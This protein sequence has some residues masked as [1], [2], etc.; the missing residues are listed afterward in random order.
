MKSIDAH[1]NKKQ[2]LFVDIALAIFAS[3]GLLIPILF[4]INWGSIQPTPAG[5]TIWIAA[6]PPAFWWNLA[7]IFCFLVCVA[8][9]GIGRRQTL[10]AK[11]SADFLGEIRRGPYLILVA[12]IVGGF[13][14]A[15]VLAVSVLT[16]ALVPQISTATQSAS[17]PNLTTQSAL[18]AYA[19]QY[20]TAFAALL[21]GVAA[22]LVIGIFYRRLAPYQNLWELLDE[23]RADL[24]K[25]DH[26]SGK[27]K[28]IWWSYPGFCLGAY[29]SFNEDGSPDEWAYR[30]YSAFVLALQDAAKDT[31]VKFDAIVY[32]Q[33]CLESFYASYSEQA[34]TRIGGGLAT[35]M[36]DPTK[37]SGE[38]RK[39]LKSR[40]VVKAL[41]EEKN[42]ATSHQLRNAANNKIYRAKKPDA[43]PACV[44]VIGDTVYQITNF[45]MPIFTPMNGVLGSPFDAIRGVFMPSS[46]HPSSHLLKLMVFRR[47]DS[48]FADQVVEYLNRHAVA[49]LALNQLET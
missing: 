13:Y 3:A 24:K 40:Q 19:D 15:S 25:L 31:K 34:H 14:A 41:E 1:K 12:A 44:I 2:G 28:R 37:L 39:N 35:L 33:D 4:L 20:P 27:N 7:S 6:L 48:E 23:I 30:K 8:I 49:A 36:A 9:I 16:H 42:I 11:R 29:R 18:H 26:L 32:G 45:G 5:I 38:L 43:L 21:S 17:S 46:G 10:L 47:E 22:V